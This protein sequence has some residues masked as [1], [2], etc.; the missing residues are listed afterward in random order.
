MGDEQ[1]SGRPHM[2]PVYV[3]HVEDEQESGIHPTMRKGHEE[4]EDENEV[5]QS[6][7]MLNSNNF[8]LFLFMVVF[9]FAGYYLG[10][11]RK[12]NSK[13]VPILE[14]EMSYGAQLKA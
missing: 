7:S 2:P 4:V 14:T 12:T 5:G 6:S 9:G 13:M 8:Y 3:R 11:Y 1:E 10:N